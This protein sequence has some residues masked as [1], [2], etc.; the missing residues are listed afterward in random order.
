[1]ASAI[2]DELSH[3]LPWNTNGHAL[4][5]CGGHNKTVLREHVGCQEQLFVFLKIVRHRIGPN[6]AR[7]LIKSDTYIIMAVAHRADW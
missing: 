7:Q 5:S 2:T 3:V 1:M 4:L 6:R